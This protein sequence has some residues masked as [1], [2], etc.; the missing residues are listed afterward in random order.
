MPTHAA[1]GRPEAN[2]GQGGVLGGAKSNQSQSNQLPKGIGFKGP[3]RL[4]LCTRGDTN[5]ELLKQK[6]RP[7]G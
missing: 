3:K 5:N 2:G 4:R 1:A 7:K 6:Q